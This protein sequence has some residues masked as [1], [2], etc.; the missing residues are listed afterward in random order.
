ML[1]PLPRVNI[2]FNHATM[3]HI[4][5]DHS[6]FFGEN[7]PKANHQHFH[8]LSPPRFQGAASLNSIGQSMVAQGAPLV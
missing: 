4:V 7:T 2:G 6:Q 1:L 8:Q 3:M 5:A